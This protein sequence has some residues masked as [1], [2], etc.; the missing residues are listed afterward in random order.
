MIEHHELGWSRYL[1][2]PLVALLVLASFLAALT[3][4]LLPKRWRT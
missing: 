3:L 4:P 2:L 1:V